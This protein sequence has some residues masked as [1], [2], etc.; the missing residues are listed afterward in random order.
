MPEGDDVI[1][2]FRSLKMEEFVQKYFLL[3]GGKRTVT[4]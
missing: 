2:P 3:Y 1:K 4:R